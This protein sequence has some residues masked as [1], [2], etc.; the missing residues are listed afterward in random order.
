M[1][2]ANG[3]SI[4][5]ILSKNQFLALLIFAMVSFVSFTFISALILK[6][7]FLLLTLG[8]FISSFSSCFRCSSVQSL[9]RVRLSVTPWITARQASLSI[10]SSWNLLKLVFIE[11]V[12]PSYRLVFCC[13]F[14]SCLQ[15]FPASETFPRSV[16]SHQAAKVLEFHLQHQS[17]QWIF[18]TDFL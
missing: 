13:S 5:F 15:S 2:L 4:L 11:S 17:F 10:T 1:S 8:F 12:I 18:R 9:S 16:S 14:S 3:L 6:I 7:Y